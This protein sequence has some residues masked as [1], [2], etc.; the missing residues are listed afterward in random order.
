MIH[1]LV[2][3]CVCGQ[4]YSP[5]DRAVQYRSL[6]LRWMCSAER[7][8]HNRAIARTTARDR[9]AMYRALN[10]VFDQLERDGWRI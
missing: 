2:Q 1:G 8:C 9:A 5:L 3:C 7:D 10:D 4:F 6:D